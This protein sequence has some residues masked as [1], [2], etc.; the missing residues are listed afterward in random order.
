MDFLV[1][2]ADRAFYDKVS[3]IV[4]GK[5]IAL[6]EPTLCPD[7]RQQRHLSWKNERTLYKRPC[8]LCKRSTMSVLSSESPYTVYCRDCWWSDHWDPMDFGQDFD[9]GRPFFEQ[10]KDLLLKVPKQAVHQNNNAEN[11][12]YTTATTRNRNC[13]LISSSGY[14]EDCYYGIFMPRNKNSVDNIH[15]MDSQLCYE[16]I[17]CE[18]GYDLAYSQ[19][20]KECSASRFLYDCRNCHHC[21]FSYG[22]RN[23]EYVFRNQSCTK[24]E[25]E[26]KIAAIDFTSYKVVESLKKEFKVFCEKHPHLFY[27]GQNNQ[28]VAACNHIFNSKGCEGCFD[29]DN[30]EDCKILRVV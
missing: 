12:E 30:L 26:E 25:Y 1:T 22:L 15:I 20:T 18:K 24:E 11:C 5:K 2:D 6:P 23:K 27:E 14:N 13:Y 10:F 16:C 21:F 9:F 19:N 8:D 28:D 29:A 17:D 4:G 3:P 7:C